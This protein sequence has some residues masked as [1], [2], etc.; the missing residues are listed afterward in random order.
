MVY[1]KTPRATVRYIIWSTLI[2]GFALVTSTAMADPPVATATPLDTTIEIGT[3]ESQEPETTRVF[4]FEDV[5]ANKHVPLIR[6]L[7]DQGGYQLLDTVGETIV[8]PFANRNLYIMKFALSPNDTMYF[9]NDSGTPTLYIPQDGY[10]ENATVSGAKW[11]PFSEKFHPTTP[12]FLGIAPSYTEFI[13][14]GWDSETVLYG[15]YYGTRPSPSEEVFVPSSGWTL[16]SSGRPYYS[17]RDYRQYVLIH[18]SSYHFGFSNRPIYSIGPRPYSGHVFQGCVTYPRNNNRPDYNRP[19]IRPSNGNERHDFYGNSPRY[20]GNHGDR[21]N[22]SGYGKPGVRD[23][24]NSI[25]GNHPFNGSRP[26]SHDNDNDPPRFMGKPNFVESRD[27]T[28]GLVVDKPN[29]NSGSKP[30]SQKEVRPDRDRD[31]DRISGGRT[32]GGGRTAPSGRTPGGGR[33]S[34]SGV[35]GGRGNR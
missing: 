32:P 24:T 10:L 26:D 22:Q 9:V 14:T 7:F 21:D 11:Y 16:F 20:S 6:A 30:S 17:W 31:K 34:Q 23:G 13:D 5:P 28:P 2:A 25:I 15:G 4:N 35:R 29:R 33:S 27:R 8:V 19:K 3:Q 18:P 12:V 1:T